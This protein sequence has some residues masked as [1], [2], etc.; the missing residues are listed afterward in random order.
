M[1]KLSALFLCALIALTALANTMAREDREPE[2]KTGFEIKKTVAG[3]KYMVAAANPYAVKAGQLMLAQ[4]GSAIDAAIAVQLVLTL[5]E[6]QSS[7][8]GGG[9]FILNYNQQTKTLITYDGRETAPL[10]ATHWATTRFASRATPTAR[11]A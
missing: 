8:I 2:A 11:M 9:A 1:F 10:A 6:P 4:G 3:Q 5:V 7:G